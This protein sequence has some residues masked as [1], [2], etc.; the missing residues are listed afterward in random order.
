MEYPDVNTYLKNEHFQDNPTVLCFKKWEYVEN[1]DDPAD[2]PK[3]VKLTAKQKR[4]YV[5]GKSHRKF[6]ID[7]DGQPILDSNGDKIDNQWY[8]EKYP[9]GYTI[10]Y[11]FEE[12]TLETGSTPLWKAFCTLKPKTGDMLEIV[13]TGEG[14]NTKW[15]VK[16]YVEKPK[17]T[18]EI[19]GEE[20]SL[21][22]DEEFN[23]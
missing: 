10:K 22:P 7:D 20:V 8:I 2:S 9:E 21:E 19:N 23:P 17:P 11:T 12:G 16:K 4:K 5:V 14:T 13:R 18:T 1:V 15:S 3:K 6:L